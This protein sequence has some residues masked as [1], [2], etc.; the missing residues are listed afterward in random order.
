MTNLFT[1]TISSSGWNGLTDGSGRGSR[2]GG[3][4]ACARFKAPNLK[5]K[6]DS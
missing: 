4:G 3:M 6:S 1:K 5:I 2:G